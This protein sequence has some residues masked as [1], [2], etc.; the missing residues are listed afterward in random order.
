MKKILLT[1]SLAVL[2]ATFASAQG[3]LLVVHNSPDPA[4]ANVDVWVEVPI[5]S[6][7]LKLLI[8]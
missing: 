6:Q 4:L 2:G 8:I 1:I 3:S 5:A 7:Y